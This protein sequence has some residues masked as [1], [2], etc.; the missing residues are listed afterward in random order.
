M[1]RL[2]IRTVDSSTAYHLGGPGTPIATSYQTFDV[3]APNVEKFL[4]EFDG[5]TNSCVERQILGVE[6]LPSPPQ[7]EGG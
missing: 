1:I 4:S 2:I 3:D 6:V 5:E 7:Q